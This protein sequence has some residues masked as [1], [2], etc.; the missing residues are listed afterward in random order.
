LHHFNL[1][2]HTLSREFVR[3]KRAS[4]KEMWERNTQSLE[5]PRGRSTPPIFDRFTKQKMAGGNPAW[6]VSLVLVS[7]PRLFN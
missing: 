5:L 4:G 1:G 6:H 7:L 3:S 2:S